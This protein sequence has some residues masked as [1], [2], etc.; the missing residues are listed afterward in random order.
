MLW[1]FPQEGSW[2][3]NA[4]ASFMLKVVYLKGGLAE[5]KILG[6]HFLLL[7]FVFWC[8]VGVFFFFFFFPWPHH[9]ECGI[10]GPARI[11]PKPPALGAWSL[12]HWATREVSKWFFLVPLSCC[13]ALFLKSLMTVVWFGLVWLSL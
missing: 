5:Y 13:L 9:A 10:L 11:E 1:Q 3:Q 2:V 4:L 7:T 12:H 6:S 8:V